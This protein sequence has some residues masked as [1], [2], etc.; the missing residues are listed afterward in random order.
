[1]I[2]NYAAGPKWTPATVQE[3]HGPVSYKCTLEDGRSVKRHQ[4]QIIIGEPSGSPLRVPKIDTPK[5]PVTPLITPTSLEVARMRSP[6]ARHRP[7]DSWLER[8]QDCKKVR[9]EAR[10]PEARNSLQWHNE[11]TMFIDIFSV[12]NCEKL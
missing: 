11:S 7:K 6:K 1:M 10:T 5:V 12:F 4:D 8:L 3:Q 9:I 2:R